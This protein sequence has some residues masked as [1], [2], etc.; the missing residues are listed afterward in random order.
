MSDY[1]QNVV[2]DD[3]KN[4]ILPEELKNHMV[5]GDHNVKTIVFDCPRYSD[6]RDLSTMRIYINYIRADG[7]TGSDITENI[8]INAE[9]EN[10]INFQ[11]VPKRDA[12]F[13][14][15]ILAFLVCAE[16]VDAKGDLDKAWHTKLCKDLKIAEGLDCLKAMVE[17][18][19]SLI[20]YI[21]TRMEDI[22]LR[23]NE[24]SINS[25]IEKALTDGRFGK[26]KTVNGVEPD[27]NGNIAIKAGGASSWNDLSDKPFG[28]EG[29]ESVEEL[30]AYSEF[31]FNNGT[32]M[33][34]GNSYP[35]LIEG[36]KYKVLWDNTE[37]TCTAFKIISEGSEFIAIGNIR[38]VLTQ[39]NDIVFDGDIE[40]LPQSNEPFAY[41]SAEMVEDGVST[42]IVLVI[43]INDLVEGGENS[44]YGF[45]IDHITSGV[46]TLDAKYLPKA[47]IM[48][49]IDAYMEEALGGDY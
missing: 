7:K 1:K 17:K 18:Y 33:G 13:E 45:G 31:E 35:L 37:Y 5:Q 26:V 12:T 27:E 11:W 47:T 15:G 28:D 20:T 32:F 36:E 39:M 14:K 21:L 19:P 4:I 25:I 43:A 24:E 9:D 49:W 41:L 2:I 8:T 38:E 23:T 3:Q 42:T 29:G 46:K 44:K 16:K 22:E 40:S 10:M 48:E 30:L 6:G 34:A